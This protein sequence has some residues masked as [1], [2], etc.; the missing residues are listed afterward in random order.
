MVDLAFFE[1]SH[2]LPLLLLFIPIQLV[3]NC[4]IFL[5]TYIRYKLFLLNIVVI[6]INDDKNIKENIYDAI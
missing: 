6:A 3:L 5:C 1:R 4:T 2:S